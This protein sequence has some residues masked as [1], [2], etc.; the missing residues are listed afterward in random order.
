MMEKTW[1]LPCSLQRIL[2]RHLLPAEKVFIT[3]EVLSEFSAYNLAKLK[4]LKLKR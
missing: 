1:N 4:P 2:D 3:E